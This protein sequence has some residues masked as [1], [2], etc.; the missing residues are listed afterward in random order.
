[1][2]VY[3]KNAENSSTKLSRIQ[4]LFSELWFTCCFLYTQ[5]RIPETHIL[6][7]LGRYHSLLPLSSENLQINLAPSEGIPLTAGSA[8]ATAESGPLFSDWAS[9]VG[10]M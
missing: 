5:T 10:A 9:A 8:Q 2:T 1:M 3:I 4:A 7:A 6:W